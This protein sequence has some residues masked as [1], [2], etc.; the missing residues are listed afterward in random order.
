MISTAFAQVGINTTNPEAQLDIKSSNQ[1]TPNNKDGL[2]IPKID[3][4]PVTNPTLAQQGML[5]Y[6]TTTVGTNTPGFYYW[7]NSPAGWIGISGSSGW[8]LTGNSG[9]N[10]TT[11]FIGTADDVDIRFKRN[12]IKSGEISFTNTSLGINTLLNNSTGIENSAFGKNSLSL[13]TIGNYN[14]AFGLNSSANSFGGSYNSAFGY[15]ALFSN[16]SGSENAAFG[17]HALR[18]NQVNGISAFGAYALAQNSGLQNSAFGYKALTANGSGENNSAFGYNSMLI[19]NGSNNSAF[20]NSSLKNNGTGNNNSAFGDKSLLNNTANDNSAFGANSLFN[21]DSGDQNSAFGK[22]A[23]LTNFNGQFNSAFGYNSSAS[24]FGGSYNS[25]FGYEALFSNSSGSEN[26]AF[27]IHALRQNQVNGISAF[28]AYALAQNSGLQ[29]SAFGYKALTANGS[30]ENNSAFGFHSMLVSNI[31]SNNSAFG[32]SSLKNNTNG[33]NNSAFGDK[34]LFNNTANDNSAFGTNTLISNLTGTENSAFGKNALLNSNGSY[35]SAFGNNSLQ[36]SFT[37]SGNVAIGYSALLANTSGNFNTAIGVFSNVGS[38][39]LTN[40]TAIGASALVNT[41]NSLVLGSVA[42]FNSASSTVNVGIGTTSPLDRLHVVGNI[43]MVDGNQAAGKIMVSDANGTAFWTTP[44]SSGGGTLDQAYDFGGAGLGKTITADA[45]AVLIN[46]TD[47]LVSTG[48]L[49]SGATPPTGAGTRM[50]WYPKKAAF[51]AGNVLGTQWNDINIGNSSVAFGANTLASGSSSIAFGNSTAASGLNSSAFGNST[52]ASGN[53]SNSFGVSTTAS[54]VVSTSFGQLAV[55]SGDYSTTFGNQT[56]ASGNYSTAFGNT[57]SSPSYGETVLGI[58]STTYTPS[59]NGN[60]QFRT[61]NAT[62]RLFV[63][64]NAIDSN[65]NN[66]IDITERSD[67]MVVLKNGKVGFGN[68]NPL[69][70]LEIAAA[71]NV[72]ER[73]TSDDNNF[74]GLELLRVG[75]SSD[76]RIQDELGQL[77]FSRSTND[78]GSTLATLRIGSTTLSPG[79]NNTMTLGGTTARWTEVFATNGIINTSDRREK[80]EIEP[81]Y[82]GLNKLMNLK[83]VTFKWI[84]NKIDNGSK[85]L[86]FIAQELQEIIPEVVVDHEWRQENETA[87]WTAAERLGVNYAEVIPVLVKS[88]QEQQAIIEQLKQEKDILKQQ[89]ESNSKSIDT[90]LKRIEKLENNK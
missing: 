39:G 72:Y 24:S 42:G 57:N 19:S 33:N 50:I 35:N 68:S 9:T 52:T 1:A 56:T 25:A 87:V 63:L 88:I 44:P 62:D 79:T 27:G 65:N 49:N 73:I 13:N 55:A 15:E 48:T 40:A 11:N 64:G 80:Q 46:G 31:G 2:L 70:N 75:A 37:G 61:A 43:R 6:L 18:Q 12:N 84:D 82:Y 60:T 16:S 8:G 5:V 54:G 38:S 53:F 17:I 32:N 30:G 81:L 3:I 20:G 26:A 74:A 76:W 4:F 71:G 23:L 36:S 77:I 41:D 90:I 7:N 85:H 66:G 83:P 59:I 21:N 22:N 47:G 69:R 89:L 58:G 67:A 10:S 28:G 86:G 45:G 51:R 29:N 34:S 14:S 78:L